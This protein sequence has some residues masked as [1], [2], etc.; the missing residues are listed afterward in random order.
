[1]LDRLCDNLTFGALEPCA[2]CNGGQLVYQSG[3]RTSFM[4]PWIRFKGQGS[5]AH[6]DLRGV[7]NDLSTAGVGYR[8]QGDLSEWTKCQVEFFSELHPKLLNNLRSSPW[9][10]RGGSSRYRMSS[11]RN[12]TSWPCT[13]LE[14]QLWKYFQYSIVRAK[15]APELSPTYPAYLKPSQQMAAQMELTQGEELWLLFLFYWCFF[16][17]HPPRH[18]FHL[19]V[20]SL[21]WAGKWTRWRRKDIFLSLTSI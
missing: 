7:C 17:A 2:E 3:E 4:T 15:S 13:R 5:P 16:S 19:R 8:C 18:F 9:I 6:D 10:P 11:S 1:M 14:H 20:W 12:L 21:Y